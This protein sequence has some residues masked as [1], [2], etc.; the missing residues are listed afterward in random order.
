MKQKEN[1]TLEIEGNMGTE[2]KIIKDIEEMK[3]YLKR[4]K[5]SVMSIGF[6]IIILLAFFILAIKKNQEGKRL[7]K[8]NIS[9]LEEI[10]KEEDSVIKKLVLH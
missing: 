10:Y 4:I 2:E 6:A 5:F 3:K 8:P 1:H 9:V 7:P